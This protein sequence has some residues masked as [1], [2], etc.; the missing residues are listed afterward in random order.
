MNTQYGNFGQFQ[1]TRNTEFPGSFTQQAT[2]MIPATPENNPFVGRLQAA[3]SPI[4]TNY[5]SVFNA[6]PSYPYAGAAFSGAPTYAHQAYYGQPVV[7]GFMGYGYNPGLAYPQYAPVAYGY[8]PQAPVVPS[9]MSREVAHVQPVVDEEKE[10]R[11]QLNADKAFEKVLELQAE[12]NDLVDEKG[13]LEGKMSSEEDMV[14]VSQLY[15]EIK[16]KEA[17]IVDA[18]EEAD[19][20]KLMLVSY[21]MSNMNI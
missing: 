11:L 20:A 1:A 10:L 19:A 14:V 18:I 4:A 17:E 15:A 3:A 7:P 16:S 6:Q 2:G 13:Q 5:S 9:V 12:M 21:K 8:N